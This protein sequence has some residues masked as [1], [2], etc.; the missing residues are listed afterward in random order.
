MGLTFTVDTDIIVVEGQ[1]SKDRTFK[2]TSKVQ[3]SYS[4]IYIRD[5]YKGVVV[6]GCHLRTVLKSIKLCILQ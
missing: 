3:K 2:K 4:F 6:G 1:M 5:T